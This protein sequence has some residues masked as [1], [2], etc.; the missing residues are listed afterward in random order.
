MF[1]LFKLK[2]AYEMRISDWSSDVFSSDLA[3]IGCCAEVRL[4]ARSRDRDGARTIFHAKAR[5][6]GEAHP[7]IGM[8]EAAALDH[9]LFRIVAIEHAVER[10]QERR[11]EEHTSELQ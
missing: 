1:F 5:W 4:A 2:T 11:S 8:A 3:G 7:Q 10:V 9:A 6:G